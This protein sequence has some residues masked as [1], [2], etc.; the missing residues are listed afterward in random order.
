[1]R[2]GMNTSRND[3]AGMHNPLAFFNGARL[4]VTH[5]LCNL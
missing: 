4:R 1:M 3:E 5:D 2:D